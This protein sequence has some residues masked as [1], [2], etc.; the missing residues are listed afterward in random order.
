MA[1]GKAEQ[2]IGLG[3]GSGMGAESE[4][5]LGAGGWCTPDSL[6]RSMILG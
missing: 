1:F 6:V 5:E 3:T 2:A 4:G